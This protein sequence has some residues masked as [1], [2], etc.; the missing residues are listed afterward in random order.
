MTTLDLKVELSKSVLA[1]LQREAS[2]RQVTLDVVVGELLIE[3]FD[4]PTEEELLDSIRAGMRQ[5]LAGEGRPARAVLD[6]VDRE[7]MGDANHR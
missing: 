3:Y 5:A 1:Y 7:V 4:E 6:E 2:R